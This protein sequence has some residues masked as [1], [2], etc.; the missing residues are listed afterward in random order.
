L[1]TTE[2]RAGE[3]VIDLLFTQVIP[4]LNAILKKILAL[5]LSFLHVVTLV[6]LRG[7]GV[8]MGILGTVLM[9]LTE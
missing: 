9:A 3:R 7:W 8:L 1:E 4:S 6:K 2:A 5:G